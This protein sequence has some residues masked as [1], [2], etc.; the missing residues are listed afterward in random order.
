MR[1]CE[2]V[3][4][5]QSSVYTIHM[6]LVIFIRS[7]HNGGRAA[8]TKYMGDNIDLS[9]CYEGRPRESQ[10]VLFCTFCTGLVT[11]VNGR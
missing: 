6:R 4:E 10:G 5:I 3:K 11:G 2:R 1:A 9:Y 7:L 8:Q